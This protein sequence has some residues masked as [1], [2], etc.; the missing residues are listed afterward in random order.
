ML[1]WI[2]TGRLGMGHYYR[3]NTEHVLFAVKGSGYLFCAMTCETTSP[4]PP[5][6]RT[7]AS[8]RPSTTSSS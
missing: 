1:T 5:V 3:V 7:P 4:P 8:R 2:K 6:G